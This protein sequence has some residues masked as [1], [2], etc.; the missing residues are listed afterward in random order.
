M[1]EFFVSIYVY[2]GCVWFG[3][4]IN[5][6]IVHLSLA[7]WY[8]LEVILFE[9]RVRFIPSLKTIDCFIQD[10]VKNQQAEVFPT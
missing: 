6:G 5:F 9:L 8:Y 4:I 1:K 2:E 10:Y 7:E 3:W